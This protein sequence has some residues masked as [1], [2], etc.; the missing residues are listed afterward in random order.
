MS[1][2]GI[3]LDMKMNKFFQIV[4]GVAVLM[5]SSVVVILSYQESKRKKQPDIN[6]TMERVRQAKKD[7]A[8]LKFIENGTK[9]ENVNTR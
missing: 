7:K 4:L 2:Y 6:K 1:D 5:I 8:N 9:E 3:I